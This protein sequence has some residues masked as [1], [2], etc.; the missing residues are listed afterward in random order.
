MSFFFFFVKHEYNI[1]H[2]LEFHQWR[3]MT[4][5]TLNTINNNQWL[6]ITI[7]PT[8]KKSFN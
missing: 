1:K 8:K 3:V 5:D 6:L 2:A 4:H 7:L